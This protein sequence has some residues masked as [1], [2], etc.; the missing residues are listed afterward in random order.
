MEL[1]RH[2]QT[3]S[4]ADRADLCRRISERC[5]ATVGHINNVSY[6]LRQCHPLL[7]AVIEGETAKAVRRW[8]LRPSDWHLIWPELIGHPDAPVS[9]QTAADEAALQIN[10]QPPAVS[11]GTEMGSE[12]LR[13]GCSPMRDELALRV[14]PQGEFTDGGVM[15]L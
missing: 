11:S 2:L 14:Q 7:A 4:A 8:D 13:V 5:D 15:R 1:K 12:G 3:L 6:G 10:E 9:A